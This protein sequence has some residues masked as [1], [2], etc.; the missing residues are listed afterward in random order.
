MNRHLANSCGTYRGHAGQSDIVVHFRF[1]RLVGRRCVSGNIRNVGMS[2]HSFVFRPIFANPSW[3][4]GQ[5]NSPWSIRG[6]EQNRHL[7]TGSG[8]ISAVTRSFSASLT[9]GGRSSSLL[10]G[11][12]EVCKTGG[13]VRSGASVLY[14]W[15]VGK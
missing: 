11:G 10:L 9:L 14:T 6:A 2:T 1:R 12:W 7:S 13:D 8:W 5:L 3:R 4:F 15:C